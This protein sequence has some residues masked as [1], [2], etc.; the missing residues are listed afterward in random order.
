MGFKEEIIKILKKEVGDVELEVP[1]DK[2]FGDYSL[3]CFVL[4]KKFKKNPNEIAK[5]LEKRLK[6]KLNVKAVGPYL[7]FFEDDVTN[8]LKNILKNKNYGSVN[9]GKKKKI[10]IEHTSI[11]PN[12]SPHVGRARNALIGDSLVRILKFVNY[13]P[14]V[15]YFVNDVGKQIA[16][17]VL[18]CRKTSGITFEKLLKIYVKINEQADELQD[19]IFDL[20]YKLENGDKDV[21][22]EFRDVVNICLKGQA[23]ILGKL[24]IKYDYYDFESKYLWDKETENI[25]KKL[26][27]TG[28][29]FIDEEKRN[30][31]DLKD[32]KLAMRI[33]VFVLTRGDGTSLYGLRDIAYTID[34]LKRAKDNILVLGEDQKLYFEQLKA[35]LSLLGEDFPKVVHYSFVL[36]TEGKM[37]TRKGNVVLLEEFMDEIEKKAKLELKKRSRKV[38]DRLVKE[39]GY[40]SLK[41]SILKVSPE[42]NVLFDLDSA[43]N[44]EGNSGAYCQYAH[45]R[46]HSIL[47][48]GGAGKIDLKLLKHQKE[49]E[50]IK[51]LG[52]FPE[53]VEK[54]AI[55]L[56]P[57]LLANY[58]YEV[59]K[60]FNEFYSEVRVLCEDKEASKARV[61]LVK[62]VTIVLKNSLNLLGIEA[63]EV[64]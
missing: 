58:S 35:A 38:N 23:K 63:P 37:S 17:L 59:A 13:K 4:S 53:V 26:E 32:F 40:G 16:M 41:Y 5:E 30:V 60:C 46:A 8:V 62:G 48:R 52:K 29:L 61:A 44:F 15:H 47:K 27:K 20:L 9:L 36:L 7:N 2:K 54:S 19:E 64:M 22:R 33:P 51:W 45:A 21:R 50:L 6:N 25:L 10:L 55:E 11:N 31:L 34:K 24:G 39:I 43:L 42:K 12:A 56:K 57:N 1:Q 3:P 14:E 18:G 28:K 49:I